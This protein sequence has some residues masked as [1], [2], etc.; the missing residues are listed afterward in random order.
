MKK[1]ETERL[2]KDMIENTM[3]ITV[4][5]I[6]K[7]AATDIQNSYSH[8]IL[9]IYMGI[10]TLL[11]ELIFIEMDAVKARNKTLIKELKRLGQRPEALLE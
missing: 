11:Q 1:D 6:F 10:F 9:E 4:E 5:Q 8:H 2:R 7:K 3:S